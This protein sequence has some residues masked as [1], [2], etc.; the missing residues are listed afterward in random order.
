MTI[1]DGK[2]PQLYTSV[3]T[4]DGRFMIGAMLE[5]RTTIMSSFVGSHEEV[6]AICLD[7]N[8]REMD[9]Y[10][11]ESKSQVDKQMNEGWPSLEEIAAMH[12]IKL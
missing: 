2:K 4:S 7:W 5:G 11:A 6:E 3:P 12:G 8:R 9:R 10:A 1:L